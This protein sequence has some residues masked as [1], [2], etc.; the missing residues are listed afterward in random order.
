MSG[1][2]A[3]NE[4]HITSR[5]AAEFWHKRR[6]FHAFAPTPQTR[7]RQR[8]KKQ[9]KTLRQLPP[10]RNGQQTKADEIE[11]QMEHA[12]CQQPKPHPKP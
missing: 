2:L 12:L 11:F 8:M 4:K 7:K 1:I 6:K 5:R 10:C 9:C 3:E